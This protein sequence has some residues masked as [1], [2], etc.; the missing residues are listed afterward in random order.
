MV[1]RARQG[2]GLGMTRALLQPAAC[3]ADRGPGPKEHQRSSSWHGLSGV[4]S[5][6]GRWSWNESCTPST[7]CLQ[8]AIP[9]SMNQNVLNDL[10]AVRG[11]GLICEVVYFVIVRMGLPGNDNFV[12]KI[13]CSNFRTPGLK[14]KKLVLN[15][16]NF[17]INALQY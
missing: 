13:D 8:N 9:T 5:S 10:G 2:V 6:S 11:K 7:C 14:Q 3:I 4:K 17:K 16:F 1:S 12:L 15:Y